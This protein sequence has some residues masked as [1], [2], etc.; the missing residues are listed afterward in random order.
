STTWYNGHTNVSRTGLP[1]GEYF[2]TVFD[3]LGLCYEVFRNYTYPTT[4]VSIDTVLT[5]THCDFYSDDDLKNRA[6]NGS[7]E[8]TKITTQNAEYTDFSDFTFVW[9]DIYQQTTKKA[10]N[11]PIGDYY[12]NI[13]GKNECVSRIYAG[14]IVSEIE[15]NPTISSVVSADESATTICFGDS[16]QL[17]AQSFESIMSGYS[18]TLT[19]KKYT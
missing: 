15:L 18:P 14:K 4:V 1:A 17:Q 3:S 6:A 7:I 10:E 8:I 9:E 2:F 19:N 13:Q 11:L 5:H 16:L 12:V